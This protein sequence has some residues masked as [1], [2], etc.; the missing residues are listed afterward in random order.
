MEGETGPEE[1]N[2]GREAQKNGCS[3]VSEEPEGGGNEDEVADAEARLGEK[4]H[5]IDGEAAQWAASGEAQIAK[6]G[7]FGERSEGFEFAAREDEEHH[8][9]VSEK[10]DSEEHEEAH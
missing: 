1:E 6:G 2:F 8:A 4:D 10:G 5:E 7:D 9:V 3:C